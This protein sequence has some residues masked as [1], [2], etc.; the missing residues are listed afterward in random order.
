MQIKKGVDGRKHQRFQVKEGTN[1]VLHN[2]DRRIGPVIDISRNGLSFRYFDDVK[3]S[4]GSAQLEIVYTEEVFHLRLI[5]VSTVYDKLEQRYVPISTLINRR[6]GVK[7]EK[8]NDYQA[9]L[10]KYF[11]QKFTIDES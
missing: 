2:H 8:L 5:P 6:C 11:I 7:F 9:S 1:A 4:S 10:V 3:G